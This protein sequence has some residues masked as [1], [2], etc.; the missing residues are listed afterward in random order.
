MWLFVFGGIGES[1]V[2][3]AS[4]ALLGLLSDV[5]DAPRVPGMTVRTTPSSHGTWSRGSRWLDWRFT[6]KK[7]FNVPSRNS[8]SSAINFSLIESTCG[9]FVRLSTWE[10]RCFQLRSIFLVVVGLH[11]KGRHLACEIHVLLACRKY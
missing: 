4:Y 1:S 5:L 11:Y 7:G 2:P 3:G 10:K 6:T 8:K 9:V